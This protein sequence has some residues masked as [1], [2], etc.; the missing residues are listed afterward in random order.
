M[1]TKASGWNRLK[2]INDEVANLNAAIDEQQGILLRTTQ[3]TK[4]DQEVAAAAEATIRRL[5]AAKTRLINER[6]TRR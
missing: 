5:E 6:N 3:R 4:H 2:E 1:T